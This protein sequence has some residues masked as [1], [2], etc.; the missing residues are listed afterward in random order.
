LIKEDPGNEENHRGGLA[1][2]LP[3]SR[4]ST[5]SKSTRR[6]STR[7]TAKRSQQRLRSLALALVL[8]GTLARTLAL[9]ARW[10]RLAITSNATLVRAARRWQ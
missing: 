8:A 7:S 5:R 9:A 1:V 4:Q 6:Q 2:K 10:E 3:K